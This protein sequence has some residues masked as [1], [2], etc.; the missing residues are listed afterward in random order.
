[1]WPIVVSLAGLHSVSE[2]HG[3]FSGI[4]GTGIIGGA[5]GAVDHWA[6]GDTLDCG[7]AW[8]FFM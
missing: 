6:I 7:A 1:M 2:F 8:D 4:L 5:L 3:S